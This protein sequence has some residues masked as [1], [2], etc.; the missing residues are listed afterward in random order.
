MRRNLIMEKME[1]EEEN[2]SRK[3]KSIVGKNGN[4]L[5]EIMIEK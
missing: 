5:K 3:R 1:K 2:K 4:I